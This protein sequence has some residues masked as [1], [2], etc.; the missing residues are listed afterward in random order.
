MELATQT[1]ERKQAEIIGAIKKHE[2][3]IAQAK[4]DLAHINATLKIIGEPQ[5]FSAKG[6]IAGICQRHLV[7]GPLNTRELAKRAM[8]ENGLDVS[9]TPR[10]NSVVYKVVQALRHTRRRN[11]VK[12]IER[13]G[14]LC[15]W[16]V[17]A[18]AANNPSSC[19]K[20]AL[21]SHY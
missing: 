6:E 10:R 13:K 15:V 12:M 3:Q 1:L 18:R 4:H 16:G 5:G 19:A 20:Q 11:A 21:P 7:E 17:Y 14:G 2:A 9:D 8:G